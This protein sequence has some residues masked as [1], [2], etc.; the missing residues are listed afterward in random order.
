MWDIEV[1]S[2]GK[3]YKYYKSALY[4]FIYWIF[5]IG[6]LSPNL[7]WVLKDISFKVAPGESLG[8]LGLNGAGKSTLL[9]IL[10]GTIR[11]TEGSVILNRKISCLLE[12]GLGFIS[13]FT[14]RQ[15][16]FASAHAMGFSNDE[17]IK[18]MPQ[19]ET[20]AEIGD[21]L[22]RPVRTYS[23]GMQAR[24]AF[25]IVTAVRPDILIIDEVL[26]VGDIY[27]QHKCFER[28]K[29]F[30]NQGT[31]IIFVSHD[32]AAVIAICTRAI[33][34]NSGEL[35]MDGDAES[36]LDYYNA[37]L[38]YSNNL[39]IVQN[40]L[41]S[42]RTQII[43]GTGE[44]N[45]INIQLVNSSGKCVNTINV[46]ERVVLQVEVIV[47]T[48]LPRLVFGYSISNKVGQVMYG[49]NTDLMKITPLNF[50]EN[51]KIT[52][53]VEFDANLGVGSYA[54]QTALVSTDTHL[55]NNYEWRNIALIFE[56]VNLHE[57]HFIGTNWMQPIM[58]IKR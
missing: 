28:I 44:A 52:F 13:D 39:K 20:F 50:L 11:P 54:V 24:L 17:I 25:S 53:E 12:L 32:R 8:I 43:S 30:K 47:N 31:T 26:S 49:T 1:H 57:H 10:S 9:K 48:D 21:Y 18:F 41:P 29:E 42:S 38:S 51:E 58:S 36:V 7:K 46:G 3:S 37:M 35:E 4:R 14:G 56:V 6:E 23:T 16:V 19:I 27:F 55:E 33:L 2:I 5:P 15:N 40:V 34:I 45:V 22:D